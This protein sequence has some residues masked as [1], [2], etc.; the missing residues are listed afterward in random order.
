MFNI[1]KFDI[2]KFSWSSKISIAQHNF[3][4]GNVIFAVIKV[5]IGLIYE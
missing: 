5:N 4:F 1:L 2:L 3:L